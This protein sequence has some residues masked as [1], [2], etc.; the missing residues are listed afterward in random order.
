MVSA[1]SLKI[2]PKNDG[3]T[4]RENLVKALRYSKRRVFF[5]P[6]D[7]A[8][9]NSKAQPGRGLNGNFHINID[10]FEGELVM[11]PGARF[12]FTDNARRG[13]VFHGGAG[14]KFRGLRAA[15]KARP[16]VRVVPEEC[17][18]FHHMDGVAVENVRVDGSASAG[19]LFWHCVSPSVRKAKI[20]NTMADGLNFSDCQ[21]AVAEDISTKNTGDDGLAFIDYSDSRPYTGGYAKNISVKDSKARGIVVGGQSGVEIDGFS[22]DGTNSSGL[23][24]CHDDYWQTRVPGGV[25]MK[26][27]EIRNA[28]TV[29]D[30]AGKTGNKFGIEIDAVESVELENIKVFSSTN[31]G[32]SSFGKRTVYGKPTKGGVSLSNVEVSGGR[33]AGF[34]LQSGVYDLKDLLA[35][36]TDGAGFAIIGSQVAGYSSMTAVN[37]SKKD[38]LRRAFWFERNELIQG[39]R[40]TVE[41]SQTNPTGYKVV[42]YRDGGGALGSVRDNVS[43]GRVQIENHS[44]LDVRMDAGEPSSPPSEAAPPVPPRPSPAVLARRRRLRLRRLRRRRLLRRK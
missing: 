42:T 44:G 5:P 19:L 25:V 4:N 17:V 2:S 8:I 39:A 27:G 12:V 35:R 14:A 33:A 43:N 38:T 3:V 9:D 31:R 36:E 21:D 40:L 30:P 37:V 13:F 29:V 16:P 24:C 6:G 41:D 18:A 26:N 34:D 23:M 1:S 22:I 7:Y 32:V 28:G 20:E 15:F 10:Y 11:E